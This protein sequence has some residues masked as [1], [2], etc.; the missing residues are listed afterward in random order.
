MNTD[1]AVLAIMFAVSGTLT[2]VFGVGWFRAHRRIRDLE[3]QLSGAPAETA[4][5]RLEQDIATLADQVSQLAN[6]QEFL[7][8]IVADRVPAP[9]LQK[10]E[11]RIKTPQ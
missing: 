11:E 4:V 8:R 2:L 10:V 9:R 1:F 6:G 3:R 7:S 5:D